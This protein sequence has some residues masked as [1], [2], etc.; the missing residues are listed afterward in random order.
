MTRPSGSTV[1]AQKV[2]GTG[3][4]PAGRVTSDWFQMAATPV[5]CGVG[6]VGAVQVR[7][8]GSKVITVM[9]LS[10]QLVRIWVRAAGVAWGMATTVELQMI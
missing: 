7:L 4:V 3:V 1:P 6:V 9:G 5:K 10:A 2:T 8:A